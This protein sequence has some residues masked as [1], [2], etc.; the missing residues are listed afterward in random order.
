MSPP[1]FAQARQVTVL[2]KLTRRPNPCR[3]IFR[4]SSLLEKTLRHGFGNWHHS[5]LRLMRHHLPM[6]VLL[7]LRSRPPCSSRHLHARMIRPSAA[8]VHRSLMGKPSR[9]LGGATSAD[10]LP[11]IITDDAV[12]ISLSLLMVMWPGEVLRTTPPCR[13]R[14]LQFLLFKIISRGRQTGLTILLD[15]SWQNRRWPKIRIIS[16]SQRQQK[17]RV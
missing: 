4:S 12:L 9:F 8:S 14:R 10:K 17:A 11:Q 3:M 13:S 2:T 7:A 1:S 16:T 15:K 6:P 5:L